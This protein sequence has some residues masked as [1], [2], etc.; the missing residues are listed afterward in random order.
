VEAVAAAEAQIEAAAEAAA[1]T[2]AADV[3]ASITAATAQCQAEVV[4]LSTT[5]QSSSADAPAAK[6]GDKAQRL[7]HGLR[8]LVAPG[9][10]EGDGLITVDLADETPTTSVTEVLAAELRLRA[11]SHSPQPQPA[12]DSAK[13]V[14]GV[15]KKKKKKDK[16][17][18]KEDRRKRASSN[19]SSQE[20]D[21]DERRRRS[22]SNAS[23]QELEQSR[24]KGKSASNTPELLLASTT[25]V[26]AEPLVPVA[27]T[28]LEQWLGDD[29]AAASVATAATATLAPS[30]VQQPSKTELAIAQFI[31]CFGDDQRQIQVERVAENRDDLRVN[32]VGSRH[33]DPREITTIGGKITP[34][35]QL[36]FECHSPGGRS[37]WKLELG[38][39]KGNG[40]GLPVQTLTA[41]ATS[42]N[43]VKAR[44]TFKRYA[45]LADF[46]V[47]RKTTG[48]FLKSKLKGL[49]E[50]AKEKAK[51]SGLAELAKKKV[52]EAQ[53]A[54]NSVATSSLATAADIDCVVRTI[55][56]AKGEGLGFAVKVGKRDRGAR[57]VQVWKD[58][59]AAK[60]GVAV[61]DVIV[62]IKDRDVL[63]L[64]YEVIVGALTTAGE[65]FDLHCC[66]AATLAASEQLKLKQEPLKG[67]PSWWAEK[68]GV[69]E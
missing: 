60:A 27:A 50:K 35:C 63:D 42:T 14:V 32:W 1:L 8:A 67:A 48:G 3:A 29:A 65:I 2:A 21:K 54:L 20:P 57:V 58:T 4:T 15:K 18:R 38:K 25:L 59:V 69:R 7:G 16:S 10:I 55:S 40:T 13:V 36:V 9:A 17:K 6:T 53:K 45:T 43:G 46:P 61:G 19:A 41:F 44:C 34:E 5:P 12:S 68:E 49:K 31:G 62:Q 64:S 51:S 52:A 47:L 56:R 23:L 28:D 30:K 66:T 26:A 37:E 33:L 11:D 24:G 39:S 22:L